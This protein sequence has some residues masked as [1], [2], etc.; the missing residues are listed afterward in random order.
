MM[1][2]E[3]KWFGDQSNCPNEG[4]TLSSN[5]LDFESFW[6]LFLITGLASTVL[7]LFY[8]VSFCYKNRRALK[9]IASQNSLRWRLHSVARLFDEKDLSSHTFRRAVLEDGSTR[10]N[11]DPGA[12]TYPSYQQSPLSISNPSY[13]EG[14]TPVELETACP[15]P[16]SQSP[17]TPPRESIEASG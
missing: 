4:S 17:E 1:E 11:G 9:T 13:E 2:I 5:N 10:G 6:G 8:L 3:R 7:C 16:V 15:T 14:A 12:S